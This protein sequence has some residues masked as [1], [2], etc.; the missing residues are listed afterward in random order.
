M[1]KEPSTRVST[2][3]PGS[4]RTASPRPFFSTPV[5]RCTRSSLVKCLRWGSLGWWHV[6]GDHSEDLIMFHARGERVLVDI[7]RWLVDKGS[8]QRVEPLKLP[9][10][11][12]AVASA[13]DWTYS[14]QLEIPVTLDGQQ[15][16]IVEGLREE[17]L[18]AWP[19]PPDAA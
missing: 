17:R 13:P 9:G 7:G 1:A 16:T 6:R 12:F 10:K 4:T 19:E 14:V 18:T 8:R 3:L 11:V 2:W 15:I 5:V